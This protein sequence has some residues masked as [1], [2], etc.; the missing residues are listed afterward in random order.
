[1]EKE[2]ASSSAMS[3]FG[4]EWVSSRENLTGLMDLPGTWIDSVHECAPLN[5]LILGLD[6]SQSETDG[7]QQGSAYNR[8]FE[9]T[10]YHPLFLFNQHGDWERAMLRRENH[11]SA[12]LWRRVLLPVIER[13]RGRDIPKYFRGV[14]AFAIPA[15]YRLLETE[16]FQYTVRIPADDVLMGSIDH[17]LT[18]PVG[19][20]SSKPK[21]F[22]ESFSYQ[23]Q[24]WDHPRGMGATG[25]PAVVF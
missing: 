20:P 7:D 21:V 24:S 5:K 18:R 17:L 4:A 13:Y 15:L 3:R 10:C 16:G 23:A 6:S 14:A 1:M 12:R 19:R 8:Y 9:Y 11:A 25:P 22:H 2:A